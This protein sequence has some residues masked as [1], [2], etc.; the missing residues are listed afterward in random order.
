[1][2]TTGAYQTDYLARVEAP[3]AAPAGQA[4]GNRESNEISRRSS[5][6]PWAAMLIK[7]MELREKPPINDSQS[8]GLDGPTLS[9]DLSP[10]N[11]ASPCSPGISEGATDSCQSTPLPSPINISIKDSSPTAPALAQGAAE[12]KSVY[13]CGGPPDT[14]ES[15]KNRST[16]FL[17]D[18]NLVAR[19]VQETYYWWIINPCEEKRPRHCHI[20]VRI[21]KVVKHTEAR[22]S[23]EEEVSVASS[24]EGIAE[25]LDDEVEV[26]TQEEAVVSDDQSD[27]ES[28]P[29]ERHQVC[30]CTYVYMHVCIWL[31]V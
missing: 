5:A 3:V 25:N 10:N 7:A 6:P 18:P 14:E 21:K 23:E 26:Q 27:L 1:M 22:G 13:F 20:R 19:D 28:E 15:L 30:A 9:L 17:W 16:N 12:H 11:S 31:Y 4:E 29:P 8:L 24:V 2:G